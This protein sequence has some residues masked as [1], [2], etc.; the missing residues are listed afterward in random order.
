M[1]AGPPTLNDENY[2]HPPYDH[3][4]WDGSVFHDG[5]NLG[6]LDFRWDTVYA[7]NT[8][9][10]SSDQR[11]KTEIVDS[12]LGREFIK[13]LRPIKYKWKNGK[14][15]HYG[16]AAQE[17]KDALIKSGIKFEGNLTEEF[18]GYIYNVP[19]TEA[20]ISNYQRRQGTVFGTKIIIA[21]DDDGNPIKDASGKNLTKIV[22]DHSN[23]ISE[24]CEN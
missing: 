7:N 18:A 9:I 3:G 2:V 1:G 20:T 19:L 16:L 14:R 17:V 22:T 4:A 8:A 21:R 10:S 5:I 11:N 13:N 24:S 6:S 15:F 12:N 23:I